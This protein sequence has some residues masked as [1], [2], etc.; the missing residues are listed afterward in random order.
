M[1]IEARPYFPRVDHSNMVYFAFWGLTPIS[2][3]ANIL[4]ID[5]NKQEIRDERID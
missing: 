2:K 1:E 4:A 5:R 3:Y